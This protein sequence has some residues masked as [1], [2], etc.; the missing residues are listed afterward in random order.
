MGKMQAAIVDPSAPGHLAL[1]EVEV[2]TPARNEALVKVAA[3]S[4]NQG[5]VRYARQWE[6]GRSIGW[7]LAGIVEQPAADGS[8]PK[9]G[10]RVVGYVDKGAWAEKAVVPTHAI[11]E[12][13][14]HVFF[15]QAATLPVAGLTALH[16]LEKGRGL[17]GRN[18]LVTGASG[19]VGLF[20]CQLAKL[21]GARVVGLIRREEHRDIVNK[22]DADEVVV[23]EDGNGIQDFGPYR[24]VAESVGGK[25]LGHVLN[26]LD[27]DGICVSFGN[28]SQQQTDFDAWNLLRPG[29]AK[30]YGFMLFRELG[31][32]PAS[33]G[34]ARLVKLVA[35][36]K[37][38]P[39]ITKEEPMEKVG[40][41]AKDLMDRKIAGKAVL[42]WWI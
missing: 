33:E 34:L 41:V 16:V 12:L 2:P 36:R 22:S 21:M 11:A 38:H 7:D 6:A 27:H 30:L 25:V 39:R 9:E 20:A 10:A 35:D 31:T 40:E 5:E 28:S 18:V 15:E 8:G 4:M 26:H 13:P 37:L 3:V 32:E 29:R 1:H 14:D 19:G 17:L 24:L 23:S 42:R